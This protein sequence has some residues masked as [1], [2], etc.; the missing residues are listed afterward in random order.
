MRS[1]VKEET[2]KES[3]GINLILVSMKIIGASL[4]NEINRLRNKLIQFAKMRFNF[5]T[6]NLSLDF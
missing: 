4:I 2:A 1:C 3:G 6:F 5:L